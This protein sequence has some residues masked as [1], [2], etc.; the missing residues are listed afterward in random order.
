MKSLEPVRSNKA[1]RLVH[2]NEKCTK[3]VEEF[4]EL[5]KL[6]EHMIEK[7][8]FEIKCRFCN[9]TFKQTWMLMWK[10]N[11]NGMN[12]DKLLSKMET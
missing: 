3:C 7:H 4:S 9:E 12:V 5:K 11:S 6:K 10:R 1:E 2:N 8:P